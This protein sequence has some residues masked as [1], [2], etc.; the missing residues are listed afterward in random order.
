MQI[1]Y[2]GCCK[3]LVVTTLPA[4]KLIPR[5]SKFNLSKYLHYDNFSP[6]YAV[7]QVKLLLLYEVGY[8]TL[9]IVSYKY[10]K[11]INGCLII[12]SVLANR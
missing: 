6:I 8:L 3:Q 12:F 2:N 7:Y 10:V 5:H 11:T 1:V 4:L 9:V